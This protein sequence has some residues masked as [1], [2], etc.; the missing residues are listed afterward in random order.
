M[1]YRSTTQPL[2][3]YCGKAI[4]KYT[5]T[6]FID[7]KDQQLTSKADCQKLT[8][9]KVVSVRYG[10]RYQPDS[11]LLDY[12]HQDIV[13]AYSTWDGESYADEFFCNGT[14]AKD[15]GYAAARWENGRLAMPAYH[16][17]LK[18]KE[19]TK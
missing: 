17:A 1:S 15:F 4:A 10:P 16:Q 11:H 9:E 14:H 6:H 7:R 8:N 3:R 2:C 19:P 5:T 18:Q 13:W 12:Q